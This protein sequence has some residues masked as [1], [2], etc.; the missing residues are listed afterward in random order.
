MDQYVVKEI[1]DERFFKCM[2]C[3]QLSTPQKKFLIYTILGA[4]TGCGMILIFLGCELWSGGWWSVFVILPLC[5][6]SI[7]DMIFNRICHTRKIEYDYESEYTNAPKMRIF[8]S[9]ILEDIFF[10]IEGF[11]IASV[12]AIPITLMISHVIHPNTL[13]LNISGSFIIMFS[14]LLFVHLAY[15]RFKIGMFYKKNHDDELI[16]L[17]MSSEEDRI[18]SDE[19]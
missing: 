17:D 3:K 15:H 8:L 18:S 11:M 6:A 12:Y 7:P 1:I 19:N 14:Y 5:M 2:K 4:L 10:V 9:K 13:A 16:R